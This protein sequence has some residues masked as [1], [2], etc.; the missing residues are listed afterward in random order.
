MFFST[1]LN[2][3][4]ICDWLYSQPCWD[5]SVQSLTVIDLISK[6]EATNVQPSYYFMGAVAPKQYLQFGVPGLETVSDEFSLPEGTI[7]WG[8]GGYAADVPSPIGLPEL[9]KPVVAPKLKAV[10]PRSIK[11]G[12]IP[13]VAPSGMR[14]QIFERGSQQNL[15]GN[16]Y[17]RG[18]VST[19]QN[20]P[21]SAT[22]TGI[23][24]L[25]NPIFVIPPGQ[26]QIMI[27][28]LSLNLAYCQVLLACAV[29]LA[30]GI[31]GVYSQKG[32]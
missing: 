14:V 32:E 22:P 31:T 21:L 29:P 7:I 19:G 3:G 26:I 17:G 12:I 13:P 27:T 20:N 8:I 16:T 23:K 25:R 24:L 9:K 28:N 15:F 2:Q 10:E 6:I 1:D 4:D 5:Q 11:Y 30:D 18:N